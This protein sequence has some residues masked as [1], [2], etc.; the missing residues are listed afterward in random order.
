VWAL[1]QLDDITADGIRD[2][3]VG[4]FS[5]GGGSVYGLD[6]TSGAETYFGA[7]YGAITRFDRLEDVNGDGHPEIIPAHFG[8]VARV[9]DGQTGDPVWS[10]PVADKPAAVATIADVNDDGVNDVVVGTLFTNNYA[11]F[12]DGADGAVLEAINYGTPV[13]AIAAIPDIVGDGSW[14]MVVGGRNGLVTCFSGGIGADCNGNGVPDWQD[15]AECG[16]EPACSDC[17]GNGLPDECDAMGDGDFDAD[18]DVDVDDHQALADCMAGPDEPPTPSA[19]E[20]VDACLAA[21][22][23]DEDVD[24][25]LADFAGFQGVFTGPGL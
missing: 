11:Y 16:G 21:F 13:D 18:G 10:A 15:I 3:I 6:A 2:V 23:F 1:E 14:E 9:V 22:D 4:D 24:V 17:N 19:G 12:L 20:C 5:F 8:T 7:G 25:D